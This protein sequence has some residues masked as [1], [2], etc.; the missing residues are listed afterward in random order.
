[1]TKFGFGQPVRR[2]EDP[3]FLTGRG[4]YLDDITVPGLAHGIF[5]R[6]PEAH[7][8]IKAVDIR[9]AEAA[10]GV[11]GIVLGRDLVE[12]GI[13]PLPCLGRPRN[14]DRSRMSVPPRH[15][16]AVDRV[17]HVG[18]A[19]VL[20]VAETR[21]QAKDA[22]ELIAV[23]YAPLPA[24]TDPVAA[25]APDAPQIRSDWP[26]NLALDF[27]QGDEAATEAA[28]AR[29]AHVVALDLVNNRVVANPIETRGCLAVPE[30][31]T[32]GEGLT[33][34]VS[35][36][37]VHDLRD[38]LAEK[39]LGMPPENLRVVC[40][41][42]GGGFGLKIFVYPEYVAVL[43][44]ARSLGR[45]VKWTAERSEG[46]VSD[47]HG[48]GHVTHAE[49]ALDAQGRMLALKVDTVAD[50][51]AYLSQ[52]GPMVS[53]A[54]GSRMLAGLYTMEAVSQRVRGAYT[55]T[56]PIDAYR[57]AGRPESAYVVERMV[58]AAA[59][60]L[61]LSPAEIRRRNFIPPEAMPYKTAAGATYDSGEFAENLDRALVLA[62]A[63]GFAGRRHGSEARGRLRGLGISA[64]VEVAGGFGTEQPR[65]VI[66]RSGK[67]TAFVGT[68]S[69]GQGHE[70]A[71]AQL[72]A[73]ELGLPLDAVTVVQGDTARIAYGEGTDGSRSIPVGGAAL[74]DAAAKVRDAARAQAAARL[75]APAE[76][77]AFAEGLFTVPG[78]NRSVSLAELAAAA[79]A[80]PAFDE[81][82]LFAPKGGTYPNGV[83]VCEVEV[84]PETGAVTVERYS[85]VDDMGRVLNPLLLKGQIHGGVAQGLGQALM[86]RTVFDPETGQLL[87]GSFLDYAIPHAISLPR[88]DVEFNEVPCRTNPLGVKGAGEAGAIGTP[89]AAINAVVDALSA[90]GITHIDMPATPAAVWEALQRA[91]SGK[92]KR[93]ETL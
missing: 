70:T 60:Q 86:E 15:A 48:R 58:D 18:E 85:V 92:P 61:G 62:D 52:Y 83:H 21:D 84:D 79:P 88:I 19:V 59:R 9:E 67:A 43:H 44:A 24:V 63:D 33:F 45:P 73:E 20:V 77:L 49:L 28:F 80:D 81:T 26:G 56:Q 47:N 54:A 71:F 7:A 46:F 5:L 64:Y 82:G 72:L 50:F 23:D 53:A 27:A 14:R 89:P 6:S 30:A 41:D 68:Q 4:C 42:V 75:A 36:Q 69:N 65:L 11:I 12:A 22:A 34:H 90:Y 31:E 76:E 10:P 13:K 91:R 38:V 17:R 57:G 93:E 87:T 3:R 40:P 16:L 55:N 2:S 1:M 37:G 74:A 39:I 29:A 51:G 25:L 8:G 78:T 32:E 35:C 66:D